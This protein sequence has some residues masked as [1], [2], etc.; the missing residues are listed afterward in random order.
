MADRRRLDIG[1]TAEE[2]QLLG[3]ATLVVT[4]PWPRAEVRLVEAVL[5][6]IQQQAKR[7]RA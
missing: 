1:L 6:R 7:D 5:R 2:A 4:S 3:R